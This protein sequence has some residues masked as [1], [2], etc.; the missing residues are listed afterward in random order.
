MHSKEVRKPP[1]PWTAPKRE[2]SG[3][4]GACEEA[5]RARRTSL[6]KKHL[7]AHLSAT[8]RRM[9]WKTGSFMTVKTGEVRSRGPAS[10]NAGVR[11]KKMRRA[12]RKL[13]VTMPGRRAL[14]G[15]SVHSDGGLGG[16]LASF[17]SE[18]LAASQESR[19]MYTTMSTCRNALLQ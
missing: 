14:A 3:F 19:V 8:R 10:P 15:R 17:W 11:R 5:R 1:D 12:L 16:S 18:S 2:W 6:M 7:S 4:D 9:C 13:P